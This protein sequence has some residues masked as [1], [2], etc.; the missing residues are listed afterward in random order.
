MAQHIR[1]GSNVSCELKAPSPPQVCGMRAISK[2]DKIFLYIHH[3]DK[4]HA[5]KANSPLPTPHT[6]PHLQTA[7][8]SSAPEHC[9]RPL[10][11]HASSS[12]RTAHIAT[13][14]K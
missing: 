14:P 10:T 13:A 12:S 9:S 11:S 1:V 3:S 6:A 2:T 7:K 5:M 8:G 4:A